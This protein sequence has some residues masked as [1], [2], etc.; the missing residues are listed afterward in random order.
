[1]LRAPRQGLGQHLTRGIA[2]ERHATHPHPNPTPVSGPAYRSVEPSDYVSRWKQ[3]SRKSTGNAAS[4]SS[5]TRPSRPAIP[6]T[7]KLPATSTHSLGC[8]MW[9]RGRRVLPAGH[10]IAPSTTHQPTAHLAVSGRFSVQVPIRV[11]VP[12]SSN[13][14]A[15]L[16]PTRSLL[17]VQFL[18]R[19]LYER[20][21]ITEKRLII[22]AGIC[23]W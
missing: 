4:P 13:A 9:H 16:A 8:P 5:P 10:L 22:R 1:V 15:P 7:K 20:V 23:F 2:H 21:N 14:A 6:R 19:C 12:M 18:I 17:L 11:T 3:S